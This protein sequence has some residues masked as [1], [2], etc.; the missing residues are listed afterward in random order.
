[1]QDTPRTTPQIKTKMVLH[2]SDQV[3]SVPLMLVNIL[4]VVVQTYMLLIVVAAVSNGHGDRVYGSL[5]HDHETELNSQ[6]GVHEVESRCAI[7]TGGNGLKRGAAMRRLAGRTLTLGLSRSRV[8]M[9]RVSTNGTK[10]V[11]AVG[12][13]F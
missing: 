1:M 3:C 5:H 13:I 6:V 2:M 10:G 7:A 8:M 9:T 11:V 12:C 4:V